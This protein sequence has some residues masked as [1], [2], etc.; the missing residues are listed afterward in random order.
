MLPL[1]P[2][3]R[4]LVTGVVT[5]VAVVGLSP[6]WSDLD[7]AA[8]NPAGWLTATGTDEAAAAVA[9]LI[10][11]LLAGWVALALTLS[12]LAAFAGSGADACRHCAEA[13]LPRSLRSLLI[14]ATA[15]SLMLGPVASASASPAALVTGPAPPKAVATATGIATAAAAADPIPWPVT[16]PAPGPPILKPLPPAKPH[17]P[18]RQVQPEP[19]AEP[20]VTVRPGDSLWLIAAHR[21]TDSGTPAEAEQIAQAWPRWY[22]ANRSSIGEDPDLIRPGLKLLAPPS[23][24]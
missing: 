24:G 1:A 19:A 23:E 7:R 16:S 17:R 12:V 13:M 9:G 5:A 10:I 14:T 8:R 20:R 15:T 22:Q 11:W 18:G 21:L 2:H 6:Q 3:L 4:R